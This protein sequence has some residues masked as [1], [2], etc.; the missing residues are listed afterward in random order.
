MGSIPDSIT[1]DGVEYAIDGEAAEKYKH[2]RAEVLSLL[3]D[4]ISSNGY[5]EADDETRNDMLKRL[6]SFAYETAKAAAVPEYDMAQW[7]ESCQDLLEMGEEIEAIALM[8][9]TEKKSSSGSAEDNDPRY[10]K[11]IK[12]GVEYNNAR[13]IEE[14]LTTLVP[15][16]G[17]KSVTQTQKVAAIA[18][19][20]IPEDEKIAAIK[21]I[22]GTTGAKSFEKY[23]T[24][25]SAGLSSADYADFLTTL[26]RINDNSGVSQ[27][28][29]KQAV[30]ESGMPDY[31]A[32]Q[33]WAT[34]GW[35]KTYSRN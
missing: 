17:A 6:N 13:D 16:R 3:S 21:L 14:K 32:E 15:E 31:V 5:Q 33:L 35:K 27:D 19:M 2:S 34:Y 24:A 8:P 20:T 18:Y 23:K 7:A 30:R 11:L 29:F 12:A 26:D 25:T 28:E 22:Y 10:V 4:V 9:Y 1:I